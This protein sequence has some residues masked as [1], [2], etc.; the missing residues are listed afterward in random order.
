M[1]SSCMPYCALHFVTV[2]YTECFYIEVSCSGVALCA[3]PFVTV[4]ISVAQKCSPFRVSSLRC[5]AVE[6]HATVKVDAPIKGKADAAI[7]LL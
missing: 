1:Q 4:Q 5:V 6:L 3:T 2:Y 7:M